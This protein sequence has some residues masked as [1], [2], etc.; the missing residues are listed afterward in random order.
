[1]SIYAQ[2]LALEVSLSQSR[3]ATKKVVFPQA[4]L[5]KN[6]DVL[7][8]IDDQISNILKF[9]H[10]SYIPIKSLNNCSLWTKL[11]T[12]NSSFAEL[13]T[14]QFD[15]VQKDGLLIQPKIPY[16]SNN[17]DPKFSPDDDPL[18][19]PTQPQ[20][21]ETELFSLTL[22]SAKQLA[23]ANNRQLKIAQLELERARATLQG[24]QAAWFP[25]L[26]VQ[27]RLNRSQS[28][29]GEIQANVQREQL[30]QQAA[31]IPILESQLELLN[32][33]LAQS[34]NP[35]EQFQLLLEQSQLQGSL[36]QARIAQNEINSVKNFAT[37]SIDGS[38]GL[39]YS[40]YS[41]Q[42]QASVRIARETVTFNEL[43][44]QRIQE[45]LNLQ[46]AEAYYNLQ[47]SDRQVA[48]AENDVETRKTGVEIV[49]KLLDAA[50]AT[51]LDL[52]NAQVE[53]DDAIITLRNTLAEQQTARRSLAQILSLPP[54]LTP[55]AADGVVLGDRWKLSLEET[56]ILALKN[57]VEL[58]QQLAE[59]R[60]GKAQRQL[61]WAAIKP[62][63]GLFASYDFLQ[64]YSDEPGDNAF[65]GFGD[66][67][68]IGLNFNWT[69]WDGGAAL[70][71][72]K[73]AKKAIEIAEQQYADSANTIRLEVEQAYYQ[74]PANW[75]NVQTATQAVERAKAAVEAATIRF[76]ANLNTQTEVL[77]AQNR[78]IQ[79]ENNLVQA[80][81]GYNRALAALQRAV[82]QVE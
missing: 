58:E 13:N 30:Q 14:F 54:D 73:A 47:Q 39:E 68:S 24:Q 36:Q 79:A 75:E 3:I 9:C 15:G 44:V 33:R 70:A 50:L 76:R 63:V 10:Q 78:L 74:L 66:G 23:A 21:L 6:A 28:A 29:S 11:V 77:D 49:K 80:T 18:V 43:E 57:R 20:Q 82:G 37:T 27:S 51:R 65:K 7:W 40:I 72:A 41:P 69:F 5:T 19:I 4:G 38:V 34:N 25:S 8:S 67:Y 2:L 46:V 42:R 52:L 31:S 53:L 59:R 71:E 22:E 81:L 62:Q 26:S 17:I 64:Q 35:R 61:A 12:T 1:M 45:E 56:I 48:I 60:S 55:T 16:I 32:A